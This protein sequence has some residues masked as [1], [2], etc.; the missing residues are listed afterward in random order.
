MTCY[1]GGPA[2]Q[3]RV[4]RRHLTRGRRHRLGLGL[5]AA[6]N[7]RGAVAHHLQQPDVPLLPV[8][9]EPG[10]GQGGAE[11]ARPEE[12]SPGHRGLPDLQGEG[13]AAS[14]Q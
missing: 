5:P 12:D 8:R 11:G 14:V 13:Q 4:P 7:G 3:P 6:A 2:W 1:Q 10:R 9:R